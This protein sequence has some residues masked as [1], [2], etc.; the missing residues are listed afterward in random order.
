MIV[1]PDRKGVQAFRNIFGLDVSYL[2]TL[3][4]LHLAPG[5]HLGRFVIWTKSAFDQLDRI[6]GTF[7]KESEVKKGFILP[8]YML[9]NSDITRVLESQE[10]RNAYKAKKL[11]TK[12][13]SRYKQPT[14][15][16]AN[17]RLKLRLN[18]FEKKRTAAVHD[19]RNKSKIR[20]R[21]VARANRVKKARKGIKK[22]LTEN[23]KKSE[24]AKK[25]KASKKTAKK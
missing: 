18:P 10:V 22:M 7:S 19:M 2:N 11:P 4:L 12:R 24:D 21:H 23:K 20:A 9:T 6:F 13:A 25:K 15:G 1:F 3:N 8:L 16:M 5:G 17:R 14:N